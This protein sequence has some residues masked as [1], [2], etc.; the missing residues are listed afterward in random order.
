MSQLHELLSTELPLAEASSYFLRVKRA[1]EEPLPQEG[2][3]T[4]PDPNLLPALQAMLENELKTMYAYK[5]Y[6]QSL[7]DLSHHAIAEEFEQHADQELEHAEFLMRRLSVL[8]GALD[9][10]TIE[11]PPGATDPQM[12]LQTMLQL[13]QHGLDLWKQLH[14][15]V[16]EDDPMRFKIEE[17]MT[18]EQE[19][20][21]EIQQMLP[22]P[23]PA[24]PPTPVR[25]AAKLSSAVKE[26]FNKGKDALVEAAE[27]AGKKVKDNLPTPEL[28]HKVDIKAPDLVNH[29][30]QIPK[31]NVDVAHKADNA[32]LAKAG[33]GG[34]GLVGLHAGITREKKSSDEHPANPLQAVGKYL[35]DN[36]RLTSTILGAVTGASVGSKA[37]DPVKGMPAGMLI[38]AIAGGGW[39]DIMKGMR[40][41]RQPEVD[42][43]P[44]SVRKLLGVGSTKT[45][46]EETD[47]GRDR[48][49]AA[50]AAQFEK[51]K[52]T[53][54]EAAGDVAGRVAG[55]VT[56]HHLGGKGKK[57]IAA[58]LIGQHVGGKMGSNVGSALDASRFK[59]VAAILKRAQDEMPIGDYL[60]QEQ[61]AQLETEQAEQLHFQERFQQAQQQLQAKDQEVQMLQ[62]QLQE[63]QGQ[64][65]QAQNNIMGIQTQADATVRAAQDAMAQAMQRSLVTSSELV[66]QK[67]LAAGARDA[68]LSMKANLQDILSMPTPP[69]TTEEQS[70]AVGAATAPPTPEDPSAAQGGPP[71]DPSQAGAGGQQVTDGAAPSGQASQSEE[72]PAQTAKTSSSLKAKL[73]GGVA[74]AGIGAAGAQRAIHQ[75]TGALRQEVRDLEDKGNDR[76]FFETFQMV[77]KKGDLASTEMAQQHPVGATALSAFAGALGGATSPLGTN[78]ERLTAKMPVAR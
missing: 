61:Q 20:F 30:H 69:A 27:S 25:E 65:Q 45:S 15:V 6:S 14:A 64:A 74:G 32:T 50:L 2:A 37:K 18:V 39:H 73:L 47:K 59:K 67:G 33:L 4:G 63:T 72:D 76:S 58:M 31:I 28:H 49:H 1:Y 75:D 8:N 40:M 5:V 56:G 19:H 16:P 55:A 41:G 21:D 9:A 23:I 62:Q 36:P 13:E 26:L 17:Y 12:I 44:T 51:D 57:A 60:A 78:L 52:H 34:A 3:A 42:A 22:A 10:P 7:R 29:A 54:M 46:S 68:L 77:A 48:A 71:T 35:A 53:R 38:G 24:A 70:G 66:T 43:A 11:A